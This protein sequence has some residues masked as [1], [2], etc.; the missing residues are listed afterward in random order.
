[1]FA[2]AIR[3]L[4]VFAADATGWPTRVGPALAALPVEQGGQPGGTSAQSRIKAAATSVRKAARE[5]AGAT[6]AAAKKVG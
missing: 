6:R 2:E 1:M 3:A 5:T 4:E